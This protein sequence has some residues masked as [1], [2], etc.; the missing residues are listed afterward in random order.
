[1]KEG[2]KLR[3]IKIGNNLVVVDEDNKIHS[4]KQKYGPNYLQYIRELM[5]D[6]INLKARDEILFSIE[7]VL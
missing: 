4:I 1:M 5:P 6:L 2:K 7:D 3:E